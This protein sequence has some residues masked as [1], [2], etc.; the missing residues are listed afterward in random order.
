MRY[1]VR[2]VVVR[3]GRRDA[4]PMPTADAWIGR[5]VAD[6]VMAYSTHLPL[7]AAIPLTG[8][9]HRHTSPQLIVTDACPGT[10]RDSEIED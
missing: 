7:F 5:V 1:T 10:V 9:S 6:D 2:I 4:M 3:V 8:H